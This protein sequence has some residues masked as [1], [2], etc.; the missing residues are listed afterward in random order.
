MAHWLVIIIKRHSLHISSK[1]WS[2]YQTNRENGVELLSNDM[3]ED[4]KNVWTEDG[5]DQKVVKFPIFLRIGIVGNK[6]NY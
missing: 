6:S 2:A 1:S 4:F 5:Q 3:I